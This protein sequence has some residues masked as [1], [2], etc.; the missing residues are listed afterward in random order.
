MFGLEGCIL[1]VVKSVDI[2]VAA[3]TVYLS[4]YR[5]G[6]PGHTGHCHTVGWRGQCPGSPGDGP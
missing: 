1:A 2:I 3:V 6:P 4:R 5:M